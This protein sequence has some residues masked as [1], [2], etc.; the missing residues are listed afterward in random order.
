MTYSQVPKIR[1]WIGALWVERIACAKAL[2]QSG[3]WYMWEIEGHQ[4]E[5][6]GKRVAWK[7]LK[8]NKEHQL[9]RERLEGHV[10]DFARIL[11]TVRSQG[12]LCNLLCPFFFLT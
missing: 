12:S 4:M 10:K 2:R 5:K 9:H 1:V 7:R 8:R 6:I 3:A 11:S